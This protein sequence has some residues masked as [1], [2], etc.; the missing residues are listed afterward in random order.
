MGDRPEP[1]SA[2]PRRALVTGASSGIG[3]AFARRLAGDGTDLVV[4]ARNRAALEELAAECT[5][6]HAVEIEVLAADLTRPAERLEVEA[7]LAAEPGFDLLV[8]NAGFGT[9]GRFAESEVDREAQEIEL[10]VVA[11]LR[12]AR[13]AL[14]PMT[15]RRRGAIINVSSLAGLGPYPYTATYGAT[16]AFVNS[17][18]EALAEE[19]RGSGVRI[20]ALLPGFTRTAF[21]QRAG[22][23]PGTVPSFAWLEPESVVDASLAALGR[24]DVICIPGRGYRALAG[25]SGLVPRAAFRRI[26]GAVQ[27]SRY[28]GAGT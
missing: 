26:V 7:R 15:A 1:A 19:L 4:V 16:K 9:A 18:S 6:R 28:G 24:G 22:I 3:A 20:Q 14:G 13:A 5:E 21:Q 11:L 8:N 25:I 23:D 10:N 27:A 17:F 2:A 12:L